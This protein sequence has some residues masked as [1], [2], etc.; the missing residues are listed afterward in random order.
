M[1][2]KYTFKEI[3]EEGL[4]TLNAIDKADNFNEWMY[5]TIKPF[6]SGKI[7][8]IGS[9]IG[10][11]SKYFIRDKFDITLSDIREHYGN[12]LIAKFPSTEV[13]I[14][15]LVDSE[16]D[17]K[18]S[19]LF[20]TYETVYALNVVE[21]IKEDHLAIANAKKLLKKDGHLIILVPAYQFLYNRF[22]KE[23]EHY[24]RYTRKN[25]NSLLSTKFKVVHSLYFN[26]FAI[27]GWFFSGKILKKKTIPANQ[28]AF[29]NKLVFIFKIIDKILNNLI[30]LSVISVGKKN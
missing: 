2:E 5:Q 10:N 3:D 30:G 6:C 27:I 19:Q 4:A 1:Q 8:E 9:G 23:L 7:L 20:N 26:A 18:F 22:D 25:L 16:F 24:R 13:L 29:Y 28:M 12:V 17:S 14:M 15:D 11:I 21:H